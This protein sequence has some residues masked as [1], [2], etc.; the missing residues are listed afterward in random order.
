[1]RTFVIDAS[2]VVKWVF[3]EREEENH[4]SEALQLLK[5]IKKG[6]IR[7]IQPAHWLAESIAVLIRIEP[8]IAQEAINWLY[9]LEFPISNT[10]EVYHK[11]CEIS[12]K[13]NHHLFDTL[14]H[15]VA[16]DHNNAKFI[17][18]DEQYYKK[19]FKLGA[20]MRL[21]DFSIYDE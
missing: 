4:A 20:I 12:K 2:V 21:A 17:T 5:E 6:M 13:Y 18:A 3:P 14:Y 8:S 9:A 16:L 11:A 15:A 1:M 10:I 7:V 19:N